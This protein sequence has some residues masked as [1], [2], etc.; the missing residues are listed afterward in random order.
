ML[1]RLAPSILEEVCRRA[2]VGALPVANP[3]QALFVELYGRGHPRSE[4]LRFLLFAAPIVRRI[5][6]ASVSGD[7]QLGA[8]D[9]TIADVK[10][11][12]QWLDETDPLCSRMI[13]LYYFAGLSIR[14]IGAVLSVS[15]LAVIR[16]LRFA[17]AWLRI[18]LP[19]DE[20]SC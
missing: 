5:T 6:V 18:K 10:S 17:K 12:L 8:S 2:S 11:W 9:I 3:L 19:P 14:E 7:G 4:Q 20:P 16:E 13:D 15:P 1:I